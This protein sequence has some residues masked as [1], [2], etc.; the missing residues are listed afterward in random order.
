MGTKQYALQAVNGQQIIV[1]PG[2][3]LEAQQI[4]LAWDTYPTGGTAT[5]EMQMAGSNVWLPLYKGNNLPLTAPIALAAWAGVARYRITVAGL[6]LGPGVGFAAWLAT[7]VGEGFPSGAFVGLR[8]LTVQPYSEA[9]VKNGVQYYARAAWPASDPIVTG[10]AGARKI[11]VKTGA[12]QV[13]VKLRDFQYVAEELQL[14]IFRGPTGVVGGTDLTIHNYNAVNPVASTVLAKKNVTTTTD[15]VEI[16][17]NDFEYFF[18]ESTA[19]NRSSVSIPQGRERVLPP[20]TEFIVKI[21][22]NSSGGGSAARVQYY[23][24]WYEG[25]T[26]LPAVNP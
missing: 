15:G 19:G 7:G 24:D 2:A 12:K 1:S 5:V 8:A 22:N 20:N 21:Q 6:V 14:Q 23:L 11:W 16:D 17:G 18:G 3:P 4:V 13:L 26:D 25:G 10:A 9:N